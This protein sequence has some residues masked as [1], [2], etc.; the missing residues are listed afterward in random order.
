MP[1]I[2]R[3]VTMVIVTVDINGG[4]L[5]NKYNLIRSKKNKLILIKVIE[6][7]TL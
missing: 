3:F 6:V 4:Y 2:F 5:S 1:S 7:N